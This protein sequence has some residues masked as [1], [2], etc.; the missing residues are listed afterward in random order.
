MKYL[1]IILT[2]FSLT[3]SAQIDQAVDTKISNRIAAANIT[4]QIKSAVDSAMQEV[5]WYTELQITVTRTG[6]FNLDTLTAEPGTTEV[7]QLTLTGAGTAVRIVFVTN[8]SGTYSTRIVNP[9]SYSG[10]T[11]TSF[12]TTTG[13]GGVI[14]SITGN[15]TS[16]TYKYQRKNL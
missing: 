15:T 1:A 9:A 11:G 6:S 8:T 4:A 13:T 2:L 10:P 3:A 5:V 12:N 7:Y 14:V 16:R